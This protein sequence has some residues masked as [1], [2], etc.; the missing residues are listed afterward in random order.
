MFFKD[1]VNCQSIS[2]LTLIVLAVSLALTS[3]YLVSLI[4][5]SWKNYQYIGRSPEFQ[6]R[7]TFEGM[8]KVTIQ[9]DIA[10]LN[11]GLVTDKSTV[12]AAQKENTEKM[13]AIVKALKDDF[14][15]TDDDIQT[16]EYRIN[17]RY[18][19]ADNVQRIIGYSVNQTVNVKVRDFEKIGEILAR[20]GNLGANQVSGPNF[21]IDDPEIY[22][23]QAR[24]EAIQKAKEKAKI[25][26][27]QVGFNLGR[28][29]NFSE[30]IYAPDYP[31]A[32]TRESAYGLG[33]ADSMV[34]EIESGSQEISVMIYITYE[35]K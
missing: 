28:I 24:E 4:R 20:A 19:W 21:T 29:V 33:G 16:S 22:R 26:S 31:M 8:G 1:D 5:N 18:S 17:P 27:Q 3:V 14:K 25:L 13:N 15:I 6:D 11:I 32:Y 9:P 30:N 34:P 7:V 12:A 23:A 10:L 2:K 35:I